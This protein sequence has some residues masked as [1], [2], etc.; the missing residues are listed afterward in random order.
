MNKVLV[1]F[2]ITPSMTNRTPCTTTSSKP[3]QKAL[4]K[5]PHASSCKVKRRVRQRLH[6]K[7]GSLLS[8]EERFGFRF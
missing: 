8:T 4:M 1:R 5:K 2:Y 6:K 7:L 3:A